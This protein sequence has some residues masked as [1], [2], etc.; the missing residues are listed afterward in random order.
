MIF[1]AVTFWAIAGHQNG[2]AGSAHAFGVLLVCAGVFPILLGL[3]LS[4]RLF[5]LKQSHQLSEIRSLKH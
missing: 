2:Q 4:V 1:G 3:S 5:Y